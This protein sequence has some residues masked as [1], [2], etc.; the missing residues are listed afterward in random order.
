V[1]KLTSNVPTKV[2]IIYICYNDDENLE[3]TDS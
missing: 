1:T 2:T 3:S